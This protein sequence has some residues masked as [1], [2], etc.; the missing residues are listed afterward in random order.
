MQTRRQN[1]ESRDGA[2]DFPTERPQERN[3]NDWK[4]APRD[5]SNAPR[6]DERPAKAQGEA[7]PN[8][9]AGAASPAPD[10]APPSTLPPEERARWQPEPTPAAVEGSAVEGGATRAGG[11]PGRWERIARRAYRHAEAR[12]FAPGGELDDWLRAEAEVDAE[13]RIDAER[14]DARRAAADDAVAGGG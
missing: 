9:V 7:L 13:A 1:P 2:A 3:A 10:D 14:G 8:A 4:P 12:G 5:A 11:V 6:A